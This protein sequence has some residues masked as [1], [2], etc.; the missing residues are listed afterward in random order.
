[1]DKTP[2]PT[3]R[4]TMN[5]QVGEIVRLVTIAVSPNTS[6]A[7]ALS[8]MAANRVGSIVVMTHDR[9]PVG[10]MTL[11]DVLLR[12]ALP[13]TNQGLPISTIMTVAPVC[14]PALATIHRAALH[15]AKA[16]LRHL[17][18]THEDGTL[19]GVISK[20]DI[21]TL[22]CSACVTARTNTLT[23]ELGPASELASAA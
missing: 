2:T 21:Y 15:M 1:M 9:I 16:N 22:L 7:E 4:P 17:L 20:N 5:S 13:Q 18:V 8:L 23:R 6:I 14:I 10:I 12:V 11:Q 19:A 3:K